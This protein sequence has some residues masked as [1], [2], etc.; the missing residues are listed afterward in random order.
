MSSGSVAGA[1]GSPSREWHASVS[2]PPS[3]LPAALRYNAHTSGSL[4][5]ARPHLAGDRQAIVAEANRLARA[6][7]HPAQWALS[8][9]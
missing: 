8:S 7:P 5:H 4:R 9:R 6:H 1:G 2:H 3:S